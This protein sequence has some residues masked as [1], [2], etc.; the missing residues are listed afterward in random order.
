MLAA[1]ISRAEVYTPRSP[2]KNQVNGRPRSNTPIYSKPRTFPSSPLCG[3]WAF[4]PKH[5]VV[6]TSIFHDGGH[7]SVYIASKGL[8]EVMSRELVFVG[9]AREAESC[10]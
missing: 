2:R 3:K 10:V 5:P 8:S 1:Y 7:S 4:L 6:R 9:N